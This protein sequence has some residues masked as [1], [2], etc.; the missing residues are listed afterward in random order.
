MKLRQEI[1]MS[2]VKP[3]PERELQC[4]QAIGIVNRHEAALSIYQ[5]NLKVPDWVRGGQIIPFE[6]LELGEKLGGGGFGDV[7]T[8]FWERKIV[9]VKKLRVQ[10]VS[11]AKK[12]EFQVCEFI[13]QDSPQQKTTL[14]VVL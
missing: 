11:Q 12:E 9:A 7:H 3:D 14:I 6:S 13:N 5:N 1:R 8:A 4:E 2:N 10:R